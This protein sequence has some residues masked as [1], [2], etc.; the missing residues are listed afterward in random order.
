MTAGLRLGPIENAVQLCVDMQNMFRGESPWAMPW[1]EKVLP[2]ILRLV[3]TQ[4]ERT[5]F[6]RFVPPPDSDTARGAW[7]RYYQ[8]WD[9]MTRDN[10]APFQ[11]EL[12]PELAEHV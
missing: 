10:L 1:F 2:N 12:V 11:L 4:P 9:R 3:L 5:V 6:T 8:R 7:R